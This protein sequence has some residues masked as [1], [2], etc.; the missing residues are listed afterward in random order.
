[1]RQRARILLADDHTLVTEALVRLL[2]PQ[3]EVVGTVA[4]GRA[5]LEAVREL[6]PDVVIVDIAMPMLNGLD[7]ARQ[8]REDGLECRLIF[9]TMAQDADLAAEA[10]RVGASGYLLKTSAGWEL[11]QAVESTLRGGS[12]VTPSLGP[13]L[14]ARPAAEPDQGPHPELTPRQREV[15]ELLARGQ[16]MKQVAA[17]LGL[18][19]RTVAFHKYQIMA[20]FRLHSTAE[21]I[22]LAIRR[23]VIA[24]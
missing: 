19:T 24:P 3:Y 10:F 17:D 13:A 15:L 2:E 7:A 12:Y 20:R 14:Q 16:S 18:T 9:L 23:G 6:R 21:L 5:L 11:K 1:M 4:D 8:I 22:Q